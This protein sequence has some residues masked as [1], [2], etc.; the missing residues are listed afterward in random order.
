MFYAARLILRGHAEAVGVRVRIQCLYSAA[1]HAER[2]KAR[3]EKN[4][5]SWRNNL[6]AERKLNSFGHAPFYES[7]R[8]RSDTQFAMALGLPLTK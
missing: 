5:A 2:V 7:K 4:S 1:G 6:K 3:I 8:S